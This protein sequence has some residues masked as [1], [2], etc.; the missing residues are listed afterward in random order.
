MPRFSETEKENIRQKLLA[1][2]E[3]LFVIYGLKKVTIDNLIETANIAKATY[4]KF[5][6]SKESLY[7]DIVQGIQKKIFLELETLLDNNKDL[8]GK[9]RVKQVF[10]RMTQLMMQY[11]IL[12]QIDPVTVDIISRKLSKDRIVDYVQQNVDAA[13][14]L[15]NHGVKFSCDIKTASYAFQ[16]LYHG[17]IYLQD[18][19]ED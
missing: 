11:P 18:K 7:M 9:E 16:T 5:Y 13:E 17:W 8:P 19:G 2:G 12:S 1:E 15:S 6:E 3:R 4:Y 10:D 14:S